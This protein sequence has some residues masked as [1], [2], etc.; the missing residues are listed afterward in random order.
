MAQLRLIIGNKNYSS[1]SLRPWLLLRQLDIPFAELR[2]SLYVPGSRQTLRQHSPSGLVP[3]LVDGDITVWD[4]LAICEYIAERFPAKHAWPERT[5]DRA[6]ARSVSAEMH[7]G[8]AALR[9]TYSM[10]VRKSFAAQAVA[11]DVAADIDRIV[12][13]WDYCRT[14]QSEPGPFLFGRFSIA[15]AMY[16]PVVTRFH[17]YNLPVPDRHHAYIDAILGLASMRAWCEDAQREAEVITA[18]EKGN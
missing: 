5:A 8:F 7:S 17:T 15:D 12:E 3:V 11:A 4:S 14:R 16:A 13:I 10:N 6:V 9:S 18:F 2:V 1:W